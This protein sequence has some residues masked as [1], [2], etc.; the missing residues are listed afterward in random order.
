LRLA[1]IEI[2]SLV[3]R[4][5]QTTVE[6]RD[7]QSF[8][9]AGLLQSNHSKARQQLPWIGQVPVLGT[10]FSSTSYQKEETE[11]VI[12]VTPRLVRPANP[13]ERLVTPLDKSRPG[14][15]VD[16]FLFGDMEVPND[17]VD[18]FKAGGNKQGP[19]GHILPSGEKRA[20][21]FS[22]SSREDSKTTQYGFLGGKGARRYY[23]K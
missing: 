2:P 12:I 10:L 23:D 5:A 21:A 3:V 11:L 17:V 15:D 16:I 22:L 7:G 9:I 8:A 1:N 19:Y 4:R 13:D 18:Y 20:R 14:N 6:L